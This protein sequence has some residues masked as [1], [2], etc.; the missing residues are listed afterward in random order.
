[1]TALKKHLGASFA[2][3]GLV[4]VIG[5][6]TVDAALAK[7]KKDDAIYE[8]DLTTTQ[9]LQWGAKHYPSKKPLIL[10]KVWWR[11][12]WVRSLPIA[13]LRVTI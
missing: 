2:S 13:T 9:G 11:R 6:L 12:P 4:L 7:D 3:A 8:D 5:L 10:E 1:M